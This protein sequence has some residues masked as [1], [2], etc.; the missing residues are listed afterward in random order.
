MNLFLMDTAFQCVMTIARVSRDF[1]HSRTVKDVFP[2]LLKFLT[3]VK[4]T[5]SSLLLLLS[6]II[7]YQTL[8]GDREQA[9]SLMAA[10]SRRVLAR[11]VTGV[12]S[13]CELLD[14]R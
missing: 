9:H 5:P 4:V 11:L 14:L 1:V 3:S 8:L 12:W 6:I 2:G 7:A 10:Q 13:L